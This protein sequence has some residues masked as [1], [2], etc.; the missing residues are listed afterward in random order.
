MANQEHLH[1]LKQGVEVW[2]KWRENN[3]LIIPD[4]TYA[5]LRKAN[6]V[7][8]NFERANLLEMN[9]SESD[10]SNAN[11]YEANLSI[12]NLNRINLSDADCY[13]VNFY[14]TNLSDADFSGSNLERANFLDTKLFNATLY[15]SNLSD[16]HFE[17]AKLKKTDFFQAILSGTTFEDIDLSTVVGLD[18]IIHYGPSTIG[19]DTIYKSNGNIPE[20]FLRGCGLPDEFIEYIPSLTGKGIEYYSCFISYSHRDE[21]FAKRV[22]NDLQAKGVRC[23]FAPHDMKIGDKIRATID[24]SIRLHDKLLLI[25]SEHSVQSDW[26]EH[27]VEHA[28]DL[29]RE[30]KKTSLFPVRIDDAIMDSTTGWSGN[31]KRQRHIGDFTQWKQHDTYQGAFDRLLRD[32][33][34]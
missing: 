32:L 22:H 29:E 6:L 21:E 4:L 9:L 34:A 20:V 33:K 2:N 16:A 12:A 10:L 17:R 7:K 26:V 28:L 30:R 5:Y 27:E 18:S 11:L 25:L 24:D 1:I 15:K 23:W 14:K 13:G 31:V 19:V 3:P 8:V